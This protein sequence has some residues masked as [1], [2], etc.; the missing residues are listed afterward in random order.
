MTQSA[1]DQNKKL[2]TN[3]KVD[4]NEEGN[5]S[6]HV[7]IGDRPDSRESLTQNVA[8]QSKQTTMNQLK[9]LKDEYKKKYNYKNTLANGTGNVPKKN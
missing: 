8:Q 2:T 1:K 5:G 9:N 6:D 4:E 3:D 7:N